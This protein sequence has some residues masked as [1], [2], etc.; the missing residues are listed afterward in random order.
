[1]RNLKKYLIPVII[2]ITISSCKGYLDIVPKGLMIPR[3]TEDYRLLLDYTGSDNSVAELFNITRTT[4]IADL[5]SEDFQIT[6]QTQFDAL[7]PTQPRY[8]KYVWAQSGTLW[9][10]VDEEDP[11]WRSLY[12][13]IFLANTVLEGLPDA[14][15]NDVVKEQLE[16]E[17]LVHR[18]FSYFALVNVWA[19][20][21]NPSTSA[22]DLGVPI[23]S[24]TLLNESLERKTVKEVYD[25][26]V[27]D[28]LRAIDLPNF[29]DNE[30]YNYRPTKTAA[31]AMLARVY[32]FMGEYTKALEAANNALS[33]Y[34]FLYN[35]NTD[36]V[37]STADTRYNSSTWPTYGLQK[38]YSTY[39]K[40]VILWK[41]QAAV[42]SQYSPAYSYMTSNHN[43][44]SSVYDITNDLRF[45]HYFSGSESAGYSFTIIARRYSN[46][47]Y[48]CI[49][50]TVP[51]MLLTKAECLARAGNWQDAMV[52][53]ENLRKCRIR[54]SGYAP[55][56]VS[57]KNSALEAIFLERK[58]ELMYKG[59]NFFDVKRRNSLDNANITLSRK[60]LKDGEW[61]TAYT[62]EPGSD[63]WQMPIPYYYVLQNPEMEQNPGYTTGEN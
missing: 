13:K 54:T 4:G 34:T 27:T 36:M 19:K 50:L 26:M 56:E 10:R 9:Q 44:L 38:L 55:M 47:Y 11:D 43:H 5:L 39:D 31:Y 41:E 21:Y 24:T 2:L 57:D 63:N 17:A 40:E 1:M 7:M 53:I 25:Y 51:E 22:T 12:Q 49:G 18:V 42:T 8:H 59:M 58:R 61:I 23:R 46:K 33:R 16:G 15:G 29:K 52:I 32:L 28:L 37:L 35:F 3:T 20:A 48:S 60:Y 14:K 45:N 62:L 6:T 30:D